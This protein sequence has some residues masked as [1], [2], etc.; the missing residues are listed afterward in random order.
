MNDVK[1]LLSNSSIVFFGTIVSSF[2]A[3]LFNMLMGR[4]L[5]P[6]QYG[7][8]TAILSILSIIAVI[9]GAVFTIS[10]R[11]SGEFYNGGLIKVLKRF[12]NFLTKYLLALGIVLLFLGILL[13]RPIGQFFSIGQTFP[14]IIGFVSIIFGLLIVI[15]RG[16]LQGTQRFL[17]VSFLNILEM[18]LRLLIGI[19][20]VF[21]G[22]KLNGAVSAIVL[23]T[24]ITYSIS[25]I[26]LSKIFKFKSSDS[27]SSKFRFD[28][29]EI[30]SYTWPTLI[31]SFFLALALNIDI[32][33]VKHYFSPETAGI[34]SAISTIAK[35]IL[36]ATSPIIGVMFP[37]VSEKKVKGDKHFKIFIFSLLLTLAG[38]LII[39]AL[40]MIAPAKVILILYGS[41]YISLHQLL[42]EVGLFVAFY[43]LSSLLANYFMVIKNFIFLIIFG[44]ALIM[45][46]ILIALFHPSLFHVVRILI[47]SNGILFSSLLIYYLYTKKEQIGSLLKG[48]YE[49]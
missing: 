20:L 35:I 6:V 8:L 7:E 14:L 41:K 38:S 39:L 44:L 26:P 48:D 11:Y 29:K 27:I 13:A 9:A 45:Q 3:Y 12:F 22:L 40:Y 4:Y 19:F 23:A 16:F 30:I 28:K 49:S 25:F 46:I 24:A 21:I 42:P 31:A 36:Y 15:N 1:K 34:Y 17:A 32:I 18:G 47:L 37:M 10:M 2:C 5:G 33:L 43:A